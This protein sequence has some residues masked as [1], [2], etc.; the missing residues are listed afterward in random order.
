MR[1]LALIKKLFNRDSLVLSDSEY[2]ALKK[3]Y[4]GY[5]G[6]FETKTTK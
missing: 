5:S 2:R 3:R 6:Y 4:F 1:L